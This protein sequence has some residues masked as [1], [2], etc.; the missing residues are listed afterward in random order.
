MTFIWLNLE[1]VMH[2]ILCQSVTLVYDSA[3]CGSVQL[4]FCGWDCF[5]FEEGPIVH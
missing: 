3:G 2:A 1:T 4:E 5:S